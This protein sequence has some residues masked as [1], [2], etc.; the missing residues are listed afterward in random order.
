MVLSLCACGCDKPCLNQTARWIPGHVPDEIAAR[1]AMGLWVEVKMGEEE[2]AY[3]YV[4]STKEPDTLFVR[5]SL[6]DHPTCG[7]CT[8]ELPQR[9]ML[10]ARATAPPKGPRT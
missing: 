8:K 5:L 3:A 6:A 7:H 9:T 4:S 2:P 10:K 1:N